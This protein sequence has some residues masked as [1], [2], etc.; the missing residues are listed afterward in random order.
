MK[1]KEIRDLTTSEIEE[2]I[3]SSKEE[4]FNLR[5]QLATGQLE[6]T[7]RIRTVRKTIARLKTVARE[8]EIEQGKAN[9]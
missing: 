6:E 7:A 4:L 9:Q 3:K 8:R 2:Q 5:F 1:A